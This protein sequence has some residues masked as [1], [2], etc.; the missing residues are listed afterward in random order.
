MLG[1]QWHFCNS[2]PPHV[3]ETWRYQDPLREAFHHKDVHHLWT[4][5]TNPADA[6]NADF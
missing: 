6:D 3:F 5:P 4:W 1:L 2:E